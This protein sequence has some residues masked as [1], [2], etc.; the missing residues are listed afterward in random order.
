LYNL[1]VKGREASE[2]IIRKPSHVKIC[3]YDEFSAETQ[4]GNCI[5]EIDTSVFGKDKNIVEADWNTEIDLLN[6]KLPTAE[7]TFKFLDV[8]KKYNPEEVSG[9]WQNIERQL[10]CCFYFGYTLEDNTVEWIK[11]GTYITTG[12]TEW[13]ISD[14]TPIITVTAKSII[15]FLAD[16]V[17]I[18]TL[19]FATYWDLLSESY[20][21]LKEKSEILKN[22][23][24]SILIPEDLKNYSISKKF[25]EGSVY[26]G[27]QI[28]QLIAQ[29]S[30]RFLNVDR[31]G[32]VIFASLPAETADFYLNYEKINKPP[33][34][35][36]YPILKNF[37]FSYSK[38]IA[39]EDYDGDPTLKLI[40]TTTADNQYFNIMN[41]NIYMYINSS[42]SPTVVEIDVGEF[43]E[44]LFY[45]M[46]NGY[47]RRYAIF[48]SSDYE[49]KRFEIKVDGYSTYGLYA[50]FERTGATTFKISFTTSNVY[51]DDFFL[52]AK[53]KSWT[54]ETTETTEN[55]KSDVIGD[56]CSIENIFVSNDMQAKKVIEYLS[57]ILKLRNE[58]DGIENRGYPELDVGDMILAQT[59][60]S[61]STKVFLLKNEIKYDGTLSGTCK[62]LLYTS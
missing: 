19:T 59:A 23:W 46:Y 47:E 6:S 8:E 44:I 18:S 35:K 25:D 26:S 51:S 49:T 34:L 57:G 38:P 12:E 55:F 24:V 11:C 13:D 3:I 62:Y 30:E 15:Y 54:T 1:S 9:E 58:Y 40:S 14:Y 60:Y 33:S 20:N 5:F 52:Y 48:T 43:A 45:N 37:N 22:E 29:A 7:F 53:T 2:K 42:Y 41:N 56:K 50:D 31:N 10:P 28:F 16:E 61:E 17:D 32:N 4:T 36:R 27:N 39:S 21:F